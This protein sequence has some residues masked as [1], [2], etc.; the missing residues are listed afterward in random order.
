MLPFSISSTSVAAANGTSVKLA[1][2]STM[3][4]VYK[5]VLIAFLAAKLTLKCFMAT[6]LRPGL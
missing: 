4:E 6:S 3:A 5:L 1:K 2:N